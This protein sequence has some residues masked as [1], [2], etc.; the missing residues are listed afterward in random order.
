[1]YSTIIRVGVA[2]VCTLQ[3]SSVHPQIC[4]QRKRG[5]R[6][7]GQF[8]TGFVTRENV[9][10]V[11]MSIFF[12]ILDVD[13][14]ALLHDADLNVAC[15]KIKHKIISHI[16]FSFIAWRFCT[17]RNQSSV[18]ELVISP[19]LPGS[20]ATFTIFSYSKNVA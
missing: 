10:N 4:K 16:R 20:S 12:D 8:V 1:M 13:V 18:F 7:L 5:S 11:T 15:Y 2:L 6:D 19:I 9:T 14:H 3:Y 17:N